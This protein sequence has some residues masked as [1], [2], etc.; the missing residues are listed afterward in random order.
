MTD[1][2][3]SAVPAEDGL[4]GLAR[5]FSPIEIAGLAFRNRIVMPPMGTGLANADGSVN[6][7]TV[8]Y[9]RRRA[10]GGVAAVCVEASLISEAV[11]GVGPELRLHDD[12]FLPG[13]TRLAGAIRGEGVLAGVQL[14]HPGRQTS[15]G[16]PVGPSP[17]P[18]AARAP[19][20]RELTLED[21]ASIHASFADSA[22][23]CR[24]AGFDYVEIHAAHCYLPCEFLSPLANQRTDDYGGTLVNRARFL[25]ELVE[26]V[27]AA[28]SPEYP[29]FVRL[30]G[31]EGVPGGLSLAEAV[32]VGTWL[33][34]AGVACISV[35]AGSWV[36]LHLT[37]PPMSMERGCLVPLARAIKEA[38]TIPVV[39]AGRLDDPALAEAVLARG[40]ADLI[41]VG[42]ALIADPDWPNKVR[43][44]AMSSIRPC[45][46]CN[47]CAELIALGQAARCAVN[48]ELGR[49]AVW[50]I[51]PAAAVRRVMVVGAGPAGMEA[52]RIAA[53]RGHEVSLWERDA[54]VGGKY[55]VASRAPSKDIVLSF[56]NYQRDVLVE[57]GVAFHTAVDVTPAIVEREDPDVVLVAT[58][59]AALVP[60]I[61]GIDCEH[62]I[63]A[64]DILLGRATIG[65][66]AA[67]VIIGGS[68]TG[69][70][71]AE[72]LMDVSD[73]ISIVEMLPRVGRGVEQITRRRMI[74]GL[75]R[76]GVKL[77]TRCRV[78]Q[79]TP[80][81]VVFERE[82]GVS[83][84]VPADVVALAIG[85]RSR[86]GRLV[87]A[88]GGREV[89]VLGDAKTPGDFVAAV[90]QGADVGLQL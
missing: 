54:S 23:R 73:R 61:P 36:S 39:A 4:E 58:G 53:L 55:D 45:I 5:L 3:F 9:Y 11:H 37:I 19:V 44:K 90:N 71:T 34:R 14:W 33:E 89:H 12:R 8:E 80:E 6:D 27:R 18:L 16:E 28:C 56:R 30:S 87:D 75:R 22:R 83:D 66:G 70:E 57:L 88:L 72:S 35:S 82:G 25:L 86:G 1:T 20:P 51:D 7:A 47:A 42:R 17:V 67:V 48:P 29:I 78:T 46:A 62:V 69:C 84:S 13:L 38:V 59:A 31:G 40:D 15:L 2:A 60:S 26:A 10:G 79:V 64:Q 43:A 52:A 85:W 68:A 24:E 32:E 41:A 76:G 74:E 21:I 65:P 81:R 50:R 77:L 63:D 49:E